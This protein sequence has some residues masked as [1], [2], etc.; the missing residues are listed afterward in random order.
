[1]DNRWPR[2][3]IKYPLLQ[4]DSEFSTL[5]RNNKDEEHANE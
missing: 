1:M 2:K 4:F 3:S 5:N